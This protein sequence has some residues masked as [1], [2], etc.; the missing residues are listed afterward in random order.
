MDRRSFLLNLGKAAA[1]TCL[2]GVNTACTVPQGLILSDRRHALGRHGFNLT[3][4]VNFA[5]NSPY[6]EWDFDFMARWGFD[7]VRLALDYRIWTAR[8]GEYLEEPLREIDQ[9]IDWARARGIHV[10]LDLH[11][12]P[13]WGNIDPKEPRYLWESGSRGEEARRQFVDQWRMLATRYRTV[14]SET[15]SFNLVNEPHDIKATD[16]LLAAVPAIKAI[17][18][19]DAQ[20]PIV[21]DGLDWGASPVPE[22]IPYGVIQSVHGY[23]PLELTHYKASFI[24]LQG[25]L[26]RPEPHWPLTL[27]APGFLYG[28]K[29]PEWQ[30]PLLLSMPDG[31][32][33]VKL[34]I[35]V[36]SV[37]GNTRLVVQ[38]DGTKVFDKLFMPETD[39]VERK[40]SLPVR[41]RKKTYEAVYERTYTASIPAGAREIAV[42]VEEGDWL[43]IGQISL[44]PFPAEGG[45]L[46]IP[47]GNIGGGGWGRRQGHVWLDKE[48]HMKSE[49]LLVADRHSLEEIYAPW[50]EIEAQGAGVIVGEWGVYNHTPHDVALAW[51]D[52]CLDI[53]K[54]A[55]WGWALWNLRGEF[56]IL[57]SNRADVKY[58]DYLGHRLDRKMLEH[59]LAGIQR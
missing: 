26:D 22:L 46:T 11:Q 40:Q 27:G 30:S 52:D 12:A 33:A 59:L 1:A 50:R 16:Y 19:V 21:S 56:G 5:R 10:C 45:A 37:S 28:S 57:D 3:E 58:E 48:G 25:W 34:D 14:S 51:M 31:L 29:R 2:L 41:K 39:K 53:W 44:S 23:F 38:A 24:E 17:L 54:K 47:V 55:G 4:K 20:R 18:E 9:A 13:G 35:Y 15:L 8:P 42:Q 6:N 43:S 49:N 36:K 7:F 32:S